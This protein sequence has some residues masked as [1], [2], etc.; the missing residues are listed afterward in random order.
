MW[1]RIASARQRRS[2]RRRHGGIWWRI[3]DVERLGQTRKEVI[4]G[5][6]PEETHWL[7]PLF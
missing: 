3:E 2:A 5:D 4:G 6:D 1:R 7:F